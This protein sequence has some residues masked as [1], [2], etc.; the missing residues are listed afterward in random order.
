MADCAAPNRS[1]L[2]MSKIVGNTVTR[3]PSAIPYQITEAGNCV[4]STKGWGGSKKIM[5]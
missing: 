1:I 3:I 5:Y 2:C 4:I